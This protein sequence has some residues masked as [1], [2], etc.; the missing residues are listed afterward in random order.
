MKSSKRHVILLSLIFLLKCLSKSFFKYKV[1]VKKHLHGAVVS[2]ILVKASCYHMELFT[3]IKQN[4]ILN[5][6]LILPEADL[7]RAYVDRVSAGLCS[8]VDCRLHRRSK[9]KQY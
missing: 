7:P 6:V 1:T 2:E 4:I 8:M 3:L 5:S 9:F